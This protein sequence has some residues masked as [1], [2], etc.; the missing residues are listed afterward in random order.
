MIKVDEKLLK[1]FQMMT[2]GLEHKQKEEFLR[3]LKNPRIGRTCA[4]LVQLPEM[5]D[6]IIQLTELNQ[7][8]KSK[9]WRDID[10]NEPLQINEFID[11]YLRLHRE[12]VDYFTRVEYENFSL[13]RLNE[14]K[15]VQERILLEK[16]LIKKRIEIEKMWTFYHEV[17]ALPHH[18]KQL[19]NFDL[20]RVVDYGRA[21]VTMKTNTSEEITEDAMRKFLSEGDD[22]DPE[23]L[24]AKF[25]LAELFLEQQS[26]L[27]KKLESAVDEFEKSFQ[28]VNKE[29]RQSL[30]I[31]KKDQDPIYGTKNYQIVYRNFCIQEFRKEFGQ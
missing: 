25:F 13:E 6:T 8:Y 3:L 16:K 20:E 5:L 27:I 30:I 4:D 24:H 26:K 29:E 11:P 22:E 15:S 10:G 7:G 23:Y 14:Y 2:A 9:N 19:S 1:I 31:F 21:L 17:A 12:I 18:I 28:R